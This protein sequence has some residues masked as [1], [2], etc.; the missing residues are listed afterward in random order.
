MFT[1]GMGLHDGIAARGAIQLP[2]SAGNTEKQIMR[3]QDFGTNALACTPSYAMHIAEAIH[4]SKIVSVN[5]M[6]LRAG[7]F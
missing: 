3:M 2:T 1:G 4:A 7:F 5:K 6:K